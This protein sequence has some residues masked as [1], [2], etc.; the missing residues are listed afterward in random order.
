MHLNA[1]AYDRP[2]TVPLNRPLGDSVN[3][4][5]DAP[6]QSSFEVLL[7]SPITDGED[8]TGT[9]GTGEAPDTP[10][11]PDSFPDRIAYF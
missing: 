3:P 11:Y 4:S 6:C 2:P 1:N 9:A 5:R 10:E 8:L 7:Y